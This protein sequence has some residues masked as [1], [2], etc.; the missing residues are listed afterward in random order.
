VSRTRAADC[1]QCAKWLDHR[2]C[3]GHAPS[4]EDLLQK[5]DRAE[6]RRVH[7]G[8]QISLNKRAVERVYRDL[9]Q[10]RDLV[11]TL[12][13]AVRHRHAEVIDHVL[14][15]FRKVLKQRRTENLGG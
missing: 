11:V 1:I 7:S 6:V 5:R 10:P 4:F 3:V 12:L 2:G 15:G 9:P 13:W 8:R 14:V